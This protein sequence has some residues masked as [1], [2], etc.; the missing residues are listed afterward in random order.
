MC[1]DMYIFTVYELQKH[2]TVGVCAV[3]HRPNNVS[4]A[5]TLGTMKLNLNFVFVLLF[6]MLL[7]MLKY[8]IHLTGQNVS[9]V[10]VGGVI[11]ICYWDRGSHSYTQIVN[12]ISI[13]QCFTALGISPELPPLYLSI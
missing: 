2:A 8:I 4:W 10:A 3:C 5:Y 13:A 12:V 6:T 11:G 7:T 1:V 9:S